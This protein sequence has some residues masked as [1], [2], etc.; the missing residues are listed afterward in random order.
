MIQSAPSIKFLIILLRIVDYINLVH[1]LRSIY[2]VKEIRIAAGTLF[3]T[4]EIGTLFV[5]TENGTLFVTTEYGT[6][7]VTKKLMVEIKLLCFLIKLV[8]VENY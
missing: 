2:S 3:V 4:T 6:L 1:Y 5:T 8:S 7:F